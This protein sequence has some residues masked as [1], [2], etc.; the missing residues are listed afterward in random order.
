MTG[1]GDGAAHVELDAERILAVLERH[2]VNY[3]VVGGFAAELHGSVRKTVDVDVVP[4]TTRENLVRLS[5]ALSE[6]RARVRTESEPDGLAFDTSAESLAGVRMLNMVT[7]HGEVDLAFQPSGTDGYPDL[8]RA[9]VLMVVGAVEVRIASLA[10]VIRSKTA[11]GRGKDFAALPELHRLAGS[12]S[13]GSTAAAG[14]PGA[15]A[16]TPT[17]ADVVASSFPVP[18]RGPGRGPVGSGDGAARIAAARARAAAQKR[19]GPPPP[20]R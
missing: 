10:D 7:P 5:R 14:T 6:L 20:S 13:K 4:E 3:V 15:P 11:A 16:R 8:E 18:V 2:R 19:Q 1:P 9:A 12:T 17:A